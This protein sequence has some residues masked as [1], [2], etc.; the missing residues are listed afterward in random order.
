MSTP[1]T[2]PASTPAAQPTAMD[3]HSAYS[4]LHQQVFVPCFFQKL[5]EAGITFRTDAERALALE[6]GEQLLDLW[7]NNQAKAASLGDPVL[8]RMAEDLNSRSR[9]AGLPVTSPQVRLQLQKSAMSM[10]EN[11]HVAAAALSL[12]L[13]ARS[14]QRQPAA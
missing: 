1:A 14:A 10:A 12:E 11:P 2:P 5:A 3:P 9:A 6:K 7:E 13:M 4:L 8:A